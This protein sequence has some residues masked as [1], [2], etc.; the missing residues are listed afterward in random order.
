MSPSMSMTTTL[1]PLGA[2]PNRDGT[3]TFRVWA[4]AI[5]SVAVATRGIRTEL[6]AVGGG[7]HE[8][9]V[10]AA[11]GDEYLFVLDRD[12]RRPDPCSRCQPQGLTGP[13]AVI[14]VA[15][16]RRGRR[17]PVKLADL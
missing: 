9:T 17:A 1:P 6:H 13:S 4:P 7:I 10:P 5:E 2:L 3:T 15:A 11:P 12:Q 8:G 16:L 14:D